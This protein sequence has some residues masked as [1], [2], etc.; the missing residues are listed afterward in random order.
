MSITAKAEKSDGITALTSK[1][2]LYVHVILEKINS[3]S[4]L[5]FNVNIR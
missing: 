2:R 1:E 5:N 3:K 4:V